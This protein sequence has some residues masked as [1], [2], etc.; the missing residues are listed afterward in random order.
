MCLNNMLKEIKNLKEE[1]IS[2]CV[3]EIL[4]NVEEQVLGIEKKILQGV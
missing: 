2:Y 3:K 1:K 4:D